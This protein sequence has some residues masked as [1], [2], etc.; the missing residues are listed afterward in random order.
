MLSVPRG[1]SC[2]C[3]I[4][5]ADLPLIQSCWMFSFLPLQSHTPG[6]LMRVSWSWAF[7]NCLRP[8]LSHLARGTL[9]LVS[10]PATITGPLLPEL[11]S[12]ED[13]WSAE[14]KPGWLK[15]VRRVRLWALEP[16]RVGQDHIYIY[17]YIYIYIGL[18]RTVYI[19]RIW[20][21]IWWFPCHKYRIYT[22]YIWFWP[23]LYIYGVYT[24]FLA[25]KS[26]NIRSH[27]VYMYGCG[28]PY[29]LSKR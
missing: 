4:R 11:S 26:P 23:T 6:C 16:N 3:V 2:L 10:S 14:V 9:Q 1:R 21:Y 25:R 28:Q 29:I 5:T 17:I 18:A 12:S 20:P 15:L 27:S 8:D 7:V 24:V 13:S 19:H 22:V